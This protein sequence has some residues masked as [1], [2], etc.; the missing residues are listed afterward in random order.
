VAT[1]PIRGETEMA[2]ILLAEDA[3]DLAR[4][5][6]REL[7]AAG[8]HVLRA[9]DGLTALQAHASHRPDLLIL[10]WMLPRLDGLEVL[11][12]NATVPQV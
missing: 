6:E 8:Y 2:T 4:M 3:P 5:I 12:A 7:E 10:D 1:F 11:H 9:A